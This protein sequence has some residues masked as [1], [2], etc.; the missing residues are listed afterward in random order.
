MLCVL[1]HCPVGMECS[2]ILGA[3]SKAR[4]FEYWWAKRVILSLPVQLFLKHILMAV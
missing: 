3:R 2:E 1:F 4:Y